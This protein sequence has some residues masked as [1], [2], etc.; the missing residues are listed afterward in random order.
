MTDLNERKL[1]E[2]RAA[3]DIFDRNGDGRISVEEL[4]HALTS[5]LG[6]KVPSKNVVQK[7]IDDLDTDKNGTVEF[8]EF[9]AHHERLGK[10]QDDQ[11]EHQLRT[12]FSVFDKDGDGHISVEELKQVMKSMDQSMTEQ[13]VQDMHSEADLDKDGVISFSEFVVMMTKEVKSQDE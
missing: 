3:F 2:L 6:G 1:D 11:G 10:F 9:C 4:G 13:E 8:H 5:M 7:M 12:A